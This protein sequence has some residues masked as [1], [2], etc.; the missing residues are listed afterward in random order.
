[1]LTGMPLAARRSY[2]LALT[3]GLA[4]AMGYGLGLTI[5]YLPPLLAVLLGAKPA[6]PPG[7]KQAVALALFLALALGI[8]VL[9]GPLLQGAPVSALAL[10][11]LG[12]F[13]TSRMAI[14][15][16][17]EAPSTLLAF[18][19]TVIPAA[20]SISQ[21][22]AAAIIAAMIVGVGISVLC[23]WLLYPLFP[24]DPGPPPEPPPRPTPEHG[25]WLSLRATLVVMPAFVLTLANPAQYLPFLV[26][27]ILLGRE[28]TQVSLRGATRELVGSTALG[29]AC[30]IGVWLCLGLAVNLWFFAG[31]I[32]LASLL[33]AGRAFGALRTSLAP[34]FWIN[35]LTTMLILLGAAV[36]D[37]ANGRD[38]YQ[39][40]VVRMALFLAVTIYALLAMA[41]LEWWRGAP[42]RGEAT[43]C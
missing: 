40:F 2:R 26:K 24:E 27:S 41:V 8:G 38:V 30:A 23:Q 22:L 20:S 37:S 25:D 34:T 15:D 19:V 18:G 28:T 5:P 36:Q 14:V 4:L 7:P 6:P 21:A 17:K 43:R 3:V 31:W 33:L 11:T 32:V 10:V 12:V 1:M 42:L 39:A 35:T 9:I 16:G 29:G 13:F